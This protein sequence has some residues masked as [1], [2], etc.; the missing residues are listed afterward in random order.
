MTHSQPCRSASDSSPASSSYSTEVIESLKKN[1]M[2]RP[3][4][5]VDHDEA[6]LAE[7]FPSSVRAAAAPGDIPTAHAIQAAKKKRE[8]MRKAG[9]G[10]PEEG[11]DEEE[12]IALN[13]ASEHRRLIREEDEVGD[14][15]D[16]SQYLGEKLTLD[17]KTA[18]R[19]ERDRRQGVREMIEDAQELESDAD[20]DEDLDRWEQDLIRHG[21]VRQKRADDHDRT[22]PPA[23]YYP[24]IGT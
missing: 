4:Q 14:E 17:K 3:A 20:E 12:F 24:A 6:L 15:E 18:Q 2:S 19:E 21:G 9:N 16:F 5:A 22:K 10:A 23:D 8:Q 7:K 13:D 11:A 1:T